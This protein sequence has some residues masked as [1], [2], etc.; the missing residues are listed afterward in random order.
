MQSKG[1][2]HQCSVK[3]ISERYITKGGWPDVSIYIFGKHLK[4]FFLFSLRHETVDQMVRP[5][6]SKT[7]YQEIDLG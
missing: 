2:G 6:V 5:T 1:T 3:H 4:Q 7:S